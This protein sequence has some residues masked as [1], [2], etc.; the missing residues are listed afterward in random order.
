MDPWKN[1]QKMSK[2]FL[3]N[4]NIPELSTSNIFDNE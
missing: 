1:I 3:I 2:Y 4:I